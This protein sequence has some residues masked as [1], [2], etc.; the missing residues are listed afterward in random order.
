GGAD[1]AAADLRV[2]TAESFEGG[3]G[4]P[5]VVEV[6]P[7]RETSIGFAYDTRRL[8]PAA[9][10]RM[11]AH[12]AALLEDIGR[13]PQARVGDLSILPASEREQIVRTWNDTAAPH[14]ARATLHGLVLRQARLTP[15]AAAVTSGEQVM[16]YGE[17]DA[18]S[19]ALAAHLRGLGVRPG[20]LVALLTGRT[21]E[22]VVALLGVL[23]AGGAYVPLDPA[24]PASRLGYMV[25]D[26][27]CGF[28]IVDAETAAELPGAIG[29]VV[30]VDEP[31]TWTGAA[32]TP[33]EA[34]APDLA[35]VIYTSGST[36]APKGVQISHGAVVNFLESM[37]REFALTAD[38]RLVAVTT[39]SFDIAGLELFL[40]LSAGAAV[41]MADRETAL[42]GVR[43]AGL[44]DAAEATVM[45]AT[46]ATWR[47]LIDS[48]WGGRPRLK[49]L[50]GGESLP[51]DLADALLAR[52]AGVWNLYGPTET[53]IW[54]TIDRVAAG[55]EPVSIGR[56]IANT[57]VYI[58]DGHFQPAPAG[59]RGELF[60]AGDGLARGYLNRPDLTAER[61]VPDPFSIDPT[62]RMYRTGDQARYWPDGR[63]EWLGRADHQVKVRGFRIELGE[64]ESTLRDHPALEDAVVVVRE[65]TPGDR[66]IVAYLLAAAPAGVPA[67]ELR[68]HLQQRLP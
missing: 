27:A 2:V 8:T 14:D 39:L 22:M 37:Q 53:T 11:L 66:R 48:G 64:I 16:T 61:F 46:P 18:R 26:A 33:I 42:D 34:T 51:R 9:I 19:A 60:I 5:L 28:A 10:D 6:A 44:L 17:L 4:Y 24:F 57:R 29:C 45:Q 41:V 54:S 32:A 25:E 59:I 50:C 3:S 23:R 38:D 68:T 56:P 1:S 63:I 13:R 12:Y 43:L 52:G 20:V 36:G 55:P 40:P 58:V 31:G 62:A 7:G 49:I 30:R 47:Q 65:D 67:A 15:E 21:V 35:Y